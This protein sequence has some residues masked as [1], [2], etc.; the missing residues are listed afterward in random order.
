[1]T[2]EELFESLFDLFDKNPNTDTFNQIINSATKQNGI[3][4]S[5]E[6][7]KRVLDTKFTSY[8]KSFVSDKIKTETIE[9]NFFDAF[10][11]IPVFLSLDA[12][13]LHLAE[14]LIH[15]FFFLTL[16]K[17]TK[18]L[19]HGNFSSVKIKRHNFIS[20]RDTHRK[21]FVMMIEFQYNR[22][23]FT[24]TVAF[25]FK[26]QFNKSTF[27]TFNLKPSNIIIESKDHYTQ[28]TFSDNNYYEDE[29][30]ILTITDFDTISVNKIKSIDK[31]FKRILPLC[32]K[33]LL[34]FFKNLDNILIFAFK[35]A[36]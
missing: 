11:L 4:L 7:N 9:N 31:D 2:R 29:N 16:F 22:K 24:A 12:R 10:N 34:K 1:M 35:D 19:S 20:H 15:P 14:K 26:C 18:V 33:F 5:S 32:R 23:R 30:T 27:Y 25:N 17:N 8:F 6:K 36:F 3:F 28:I 21:E 13:F